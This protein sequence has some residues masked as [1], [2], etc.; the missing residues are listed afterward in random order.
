[1]AGRT[2]SGPPGQ[3]APPRAASL[4]RG[5]CSLSNQN[6]RQGT[7]THR[8]APEALRPTPRPKRAAHWSSRGI[9]RPSR[10][11]RRPISSRRKAPRHRARPSQAR[12]ARGRSLQQGAAAAEGAHIPCHAGSRLPRGRFRESCPR[13]TFGRSRHAN[14]QGIPKTAHQDRPAT[15]I[16]S[17][18][19]APLPPRR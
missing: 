16:R 11:T 7:G 15:R 17:V 14:A 2:R 4:S 10:E 18:L 9:C 19:Q 1:M 13:W 3:A 8:Q 5:P 6:S 12:A